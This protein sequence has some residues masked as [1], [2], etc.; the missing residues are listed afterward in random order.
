M[1]V[2]FSHWLWH[3]FI[4]QRF[5]VLHGAD[6]DGDVGWTHGCTS[7]VTE[8]HRATATPHSTG[9][10]R[11][12]RTKDQSRHW[13]TSSWP[14]CIEPSRMSQW[15]TAV[16]TNSRRCSRLNLQH[17]TS[18]CSDSEHC[19]GSQLTELMLLK[20]DTFFCINEAADYVVKYGNRDP[21]TGCCRDT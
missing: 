2:G 16:A 12:S 19:Q 4:T 8:M 14:V 5:A 6:A 18:L 11:P 10:L 20:K 13:D 7:C 9:T 17:S 15:T 1:K 21:K 3:L